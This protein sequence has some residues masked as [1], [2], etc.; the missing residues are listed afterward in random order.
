[1]FTV[2]ADYQMMGEGWFSATAVGVVPHKLDSY[3]REN[4]EWQRALVMWTLLTLMSS[5]ICTV[6]NNS[7]IRQFLQSVSKLNYLCIEYS[8]TVQSAKQCMLWSGKSTG[9]ALARQCWCA[10][11]AQQHWIIM[12]SDLHCHIRKSCQKGNIST[13]LSSFAGAL[14]SATKFPRSD[15]IT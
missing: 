14:Y 5:F 6:F 8:Q 7:I 12:H 15:K 13:E 10:L 4:F 11:L 3:F 1:M 9:E 2:N